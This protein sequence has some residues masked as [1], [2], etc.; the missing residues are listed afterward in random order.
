MIRD[1]TQAVSDLQGLLY[2]ITKQVEDKTNNLGAFDRS[3]NSVADLSQARLLHSEIEEEARN[4]ICIVKP[5]YQ[6]VR[7]PKN[8]NK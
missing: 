5:L 2:L 4:W 3:N 7:E 1:Y 6:I 8:W